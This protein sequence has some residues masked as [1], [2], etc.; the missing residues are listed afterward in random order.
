LAAVFLVVVRGLAAA[1]V[2]LGTAF[3]L[4]AG[5]V[6]AGAGAWGATAAFVWGAVPSV[7]VLRIEAIS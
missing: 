7:L 4:T 6:A 2:A 5:V 3:F 1:G